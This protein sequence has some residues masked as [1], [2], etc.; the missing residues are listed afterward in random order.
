MKIG[1]I[2]AGF[3][4]LTTAYELTKRGHEVTLYEKDAVVGGLSSGFKDERWEWALERFYHHWF[5]S[6]ADVI[7]LMAELGLKDK[8]F[9]PRPTTSIWYKGKAYPFDNYLRA[10]LFPYLSLVDKIR[11]APVA[12]Y[13]RLTRNWRPLERVTAHEW[14]TRWLGQRGYQVLFEPLLVGKMGDYY[15]EVNMA[16]M[17]ARLY[18]RS[19]S[20]GYFVGGFQALADALLERVR[21]QG[22]TVHLNAPVREIRP[23]AEGGLW[24]RTAEDET[25]FDR[26][27]ST[28][29]PWAMI[30]L[31][32]DLPASYQA[33]LRELRSLGALTLILALDRPLTQGHYWINLPKAEFPFLALVE[34]TNYIDPVHYGDDH[35]VYLGDYPPPEHEYFHLSEEELLERFLP[36]LPRFN[37]DFDPAWVRQS[38]LFREEYAQPVPLPNQSQRIPD[39]RTPIPGLFWASMSQVYPWDRGTNYAVELGRT[40][41]AMLQE[42]A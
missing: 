28:I 12:I 31:A 24:L 32:P 42:G 34:H 21:A 17:W 3:A 6:D 35:L 26:V 27:V 36:H 23:T 11:A 1:I 7:G 14:L 2:G 18:K 15:R 33:Q 29:S 9:F 41:S 30:Q 4:G 10:A 22:G 25:V 39:L 19:P 20:L 16:W 37:P 40:V 13:L 38:W 5:A 8:L